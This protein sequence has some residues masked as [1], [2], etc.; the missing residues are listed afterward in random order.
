MP[1]AMRSETEGAPPL[2]TS[3]E[4]KGPRRA[5]EPGGMG[6]QALKDAIVLIVLSWILLFMLGFSLRAFNI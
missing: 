6:D 3:R 4:P 5:G 2:A 1:G